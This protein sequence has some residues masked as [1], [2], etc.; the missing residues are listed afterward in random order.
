MLS[1]GATVFPKYLE[2]AELEHPARSEQR[3]IKERASVL[4]RSIF[5][6]TVDEER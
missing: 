1:F 3:I 4:L 5:S 6:I 2:L